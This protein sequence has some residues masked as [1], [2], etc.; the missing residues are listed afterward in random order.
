MEWLIIDTLA[1]ESK[2]PDDRRRGSR[3]DAEEEKYMKGSGGGPSW[4]DLQRSAEWVRNQKEIHMTGVT[5][6]K[7]V[8]NF[9]AFVS[10]GLPDAHAQQIIDQWLAGKLSG[11]IGGKDAKGVDFAVDSKHVI[12]MHTFLWKEQLQLI[13]IAQM[14]TDLQEAQLKQQLDQMGARR[15]FR[16]DQNRGPNF[17]GR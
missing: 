7:F 12:A 3:K 16:H 10:V 9:G 17:G 11:V 1:G 5:G 8:L 15:P 13:E 4:N 14:Q 2:W 6:I